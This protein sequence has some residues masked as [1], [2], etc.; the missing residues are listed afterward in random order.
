MAVPIGWPPALVTWTVAPASPVP[1]S[2]V[3]SVLT[4]ATGAVGAVVSGAVTV[5]AGE[6][7]PAASLWVTVR[8]PPAVCGVVSGR[9]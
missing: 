3:P 5:V 9:V 2:V 8:L 6:A 4:V 7:L 1:V